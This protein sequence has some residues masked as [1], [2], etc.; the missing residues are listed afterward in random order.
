LH[1]K[2]RG[3]G[4]NLVTLAIFRSAATTTAS[5]LRLTP[6]PLHSDEDIEALV[7]ALSDVWTRLILRSAA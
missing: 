7:A 6:S 3:I 2:A 1:R 5:R 4:L